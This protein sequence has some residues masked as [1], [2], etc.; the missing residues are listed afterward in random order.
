MTPRLGSHV[1]PASRLQHAFQHVARAQGRHGGVGSNARRCD[2]NPLCPFATVTFTWLF[3]R[4]CQHV[5]FFVQLAKLGWAPNN[6]VPSNLGT[7][8]CVALDTLHQSHS[9]GAVGNTMRTM[10]NTVIG[11]HPTSGMFTELG[12]HVLHVRRRVCE[13]THRFAGRHA[14]GC[15]YSTPVDPAQPVLPIRHFRRSVRRAV[16]RS[17]RPEPKRWRCTTPRAHA[18]L[19]NHVPHVGAAM[20]VTVRRMSFRVAVHHHPSASAGAAFAIGSENTNTPA[21]GRR[22]VG[23][24]RPGHGPRFAS[25]SQQQDDDPSSASDTQQCVR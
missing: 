16:R 14:V 23:S 17:T 19:S 10:S 9:L 8:R 6:T 25:D 3:R 13:T 5:V 18:Q 12:A 7:A 2:R 24:G 4:P 22:L 1:R 20:L 15:N 21:L 11:M